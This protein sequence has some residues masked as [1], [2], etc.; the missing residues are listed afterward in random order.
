[1]IFMD[2]ISS[3]FPTLTLA[4]SSLQNDNIS[5]KTRG[6]Y[7]SPPEV[8]KDFQFSYQSFNFFQFKYFFFK[9]PQQLFYFIFF[10]NALNSDSN[11]PSTMISCEISPEFGEI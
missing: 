9:C 6:K 3:F 8:D 1:M 2:Q 4:L 11:E 7:Y 10:Q 5:C